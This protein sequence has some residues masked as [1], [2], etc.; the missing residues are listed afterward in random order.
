MIIYRGQK[1]VVSMFMDNKLYEPS[2]SRNII[3]DLVGTTYPD[4]Y[5]LVSGHGDS[6]DIAEG[7][8]DDGGGFMTLCI[9]RIHIYMM[10]SI[11]LRYRGR[12]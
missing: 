6:W 9:L 5:V 2:P 8:M 10:I 11:R 3:I 7:A 4:E 1:A 12:P